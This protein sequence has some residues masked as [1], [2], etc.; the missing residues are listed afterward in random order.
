MGV[1]N[2]AVFACLLRTTTKKVISFLRKKVHPREN[3]GYACEL[4]GGLVMSSMTTINYY[5]TMTAS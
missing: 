1:I 3:P 5:S 2:S 4:P